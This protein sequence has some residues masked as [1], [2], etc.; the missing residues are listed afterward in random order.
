MR[1]FHRLRLGCLLFLIASTAVH[2]GGGL[3]V[4]VSNDGTNNLY[5]TVIDLNNTPPQTVVSGQSINGNASIAVSV[6]PDGSG[7][8]HVK[9]TA[10]TVDRDM[11][12]CGHGEKSGLNDGD[13]VHVSADSDCG[14]N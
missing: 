2:G 8:G 5:V 1:A 7:L 11:R 10:I 6:A 13:T 9:W 12:T 3:T 4:N 14:G